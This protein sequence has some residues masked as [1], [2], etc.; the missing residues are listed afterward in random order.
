MALLRLLVLPTAFVVTIVTRV[1]PISD[2]LIVVAIKEGKVLPAM[3]VTIK[4]VTRKA[5]FRRRLMVD[6]GTLWDRPTHRGMILMHRRMIFNRHCLHFS[7]S[8]RIRKRYRKPMVVQRCL[9][10]ILRRILALRKILLVSRFNSIGTTNRFRLGLH[11]R[12]WKTNPGTK[13]FGHFGSLSIWETK[14]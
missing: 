14:T 1:Q 4:E 2:V 12:R 3:M 6:R 8:H 13:V 11:R 9:R 5:T 7:P 10:R